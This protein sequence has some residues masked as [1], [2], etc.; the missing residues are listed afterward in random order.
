MIRRRSQNFV[1]VIA[2][3]EKF[4][5]HKE[6]IGYYSTFF[7]T[8]FSSA[9]IEGT[10]QEMELPHLSSVIFGLFTHWLYTQT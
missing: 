6:L 1:T 3:Q 5:I 10:T 7:D 8:A 2:S 9:F 4:V